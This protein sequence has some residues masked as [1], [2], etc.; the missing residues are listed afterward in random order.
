MK[1]NVIYRWRAGEG[2]TP[3]V[4][5]SG[6]TGTAPFA[7][8]EPGANGLTLDSQGRISRRKVHGEKI[9]LADRYQGRRLNSPNHLVYHGDLYF[10]DPPSVYPKRL[11]TQLA[12]TASAPRVN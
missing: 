12:C 2:I 11:P 6:Y 5:P 3:Y 1:N 4:Y 7:G 8:K 10:T 9:T